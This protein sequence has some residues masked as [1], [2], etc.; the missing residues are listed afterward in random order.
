MILKENELDTKMFEV[1]NTML[2]IRIVEFDL[3]NIIDRYEIFFYEYKI[4]PYSNTFDNLVTLDNYF[5][6]KSENKI[7]GLF[8]FTEMNKKRIDLKIY[9]KFVN[10][11]LYDVKYKKLDL[12]N[13]ILFKI[14]NDDIIGMYLVVITDWYLKY[15]DV[16]TILSMWSYFQKTG[17]LNYESLRKTYF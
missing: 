13:R 6:K 10:C 11:L 2:N 4:Y 14:L 1:D 3:Q 17:F 5:F 8:F 7:K 16:D 12:K 9:I 15:Y